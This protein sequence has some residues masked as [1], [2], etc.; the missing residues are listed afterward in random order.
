MTPRTIDAFARREAQAAQGELSSLVKRWC[1][2]RAECPCSKV[3]VVRVTECVLRK[4]DENDQV[5]IASDKLEVFGDFN[6]A[7]GNWDMGPGGSPGSSLRLGRVD[8]I[9]LAIF[10]RATRCCMGSV[11]GVSTFTPWNSL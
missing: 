9:V 6:F 8:A 2:R 10:A 5:T 11:A 7:S 4:P 3:E 1:Y